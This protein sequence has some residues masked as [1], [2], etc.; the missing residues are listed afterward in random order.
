MAVKSS[1][2]KLSHGNF[3]PE[4]LNE[5]DCIQATARNFEKKSILIHALLLNQETFKG[6]LKHIII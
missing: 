6:L 2:V 3:S 4:Q 5:L 1:N